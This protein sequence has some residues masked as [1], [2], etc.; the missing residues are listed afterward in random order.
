MHGARLL[1]LRATCPSVARYTGGLLLY[2]VR[3]KRILFAFAVL[4]AGGCQPQRPAPCAPCSQ[5]TLCT[6]D[7]VQ[8]QS[9][10]G[11][12]EAA[13][14][15]HIVVAS[16]ESSPGFASTA[17]LGDKIVTCDFRVTAFAQLNDQDA[18]MVEATANDEPLLISF[19]DLSSDEPLLRGNMGDSALQKMRDDGDT[20]VLAE[21]TAAGYVNVYAI[22]RSTRVAVYSKAYVMNGIRGPRPLGLTAVGRCW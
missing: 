12:P 1:C 7:P 9:S 5:G 14:H 20:I 22:T 4:A 10:A 17:A 3:V 11:T 6:S 13:V 19:A 16:Y 18:P 21:V 8:P 15:Q 2:P